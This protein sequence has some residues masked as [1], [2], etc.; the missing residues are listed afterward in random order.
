M[1]LADFFGTSVDVLLGYRMQDGGRERLVE[2]LKA[3]RGDWI[4]PMSFEDV[5]R[6]LRRYPNDFEILHQSAKLYEV[7]GIEA[8]SERWQ[9]RA[10]ELYQEAVQPIDQ[11][12][13]ESVSLLTLQI[14]IAQVLMGMERDD[15]TVEILKKHNP[16]RMNSA[17][18]G[19]RLQSSRGG[20]AVS[21]GGAHRK[22]GGAAAD[23]LWISECFPEAGAIFRECWR[24]SA[25]CSR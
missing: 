13:D 11:N 20:G 9:L 18:I 23:C 22:R 3:S 16:R 17:Q 21:F 1:E 5:E 25:G 15:E 10:L 6:A 19:E 2:R 7:R 14:D 8:R 4:A 24:F 12:E